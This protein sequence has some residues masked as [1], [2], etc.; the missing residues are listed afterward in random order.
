M[1]KLTQDEYLE[2]IRNIIKENM[3]DEPDRI[4]SDKFV[5]SRHIA[6]LIESGQQDPKLMDYLI[7]WNDVVKANPGKEFTLY[8]NFGKGLTQFQK[9]NAEVKKVLREMNEMLNNFG[10]E[11]VI[12]NL[13]E[14]FNDPAIQEAI[15]EKFSSEQKLVTQENN[16]KV[17]IS[18]AEA[19]AQ[20]KITAA[21]A[22]AEANRKIAESLT[23]TMIEKQKIEKWNGDVPTVQGSNTPIIDMSK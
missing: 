18:K 5:I 9:G 13:I 10:D 12:F 2:G 6:A 11:Y 7:S 20:A 23:P 3:S 21:E 1:S 16:N 22:E 15:N 14:Q 8:E 4:G 17:T 19:D